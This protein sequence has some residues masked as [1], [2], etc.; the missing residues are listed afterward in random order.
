MLSAHEDCHTRSLVRIPV[1]ESCPSRIDGEAHSDPSDQ[2]LSRDGFAPA[3]PRV[4]LANEL[5]G[6]VEWTGPGMSEP[7]FRDHH[8]PRTGRGRR[9][10]TMR[11]VP[12]GDKVVVQRVEAEETTAGGIVLPDAAREK[13]AE[14]RILSVG[15][16][17]I[18]SDGRRVPLQVGEG[19][20]V[21]FSRWAGTEVAVDGR[22]VLV[23]KESDILAVLA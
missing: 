18:A 22:E 21:L 17:A 23:M 14:G 6:P 2:R 19:D 1:Q 16:G 11:L 5:R 13:P 20:R 15:D 4:V 7:D 10:Y 3:D 8:L 12:L 9:T